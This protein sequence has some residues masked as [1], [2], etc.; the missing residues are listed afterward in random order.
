MISIVICSINT[1]KFVA[2]SESYRQALGDEPHEIIRISNAKSLAE[3]YN[4]GLGKSTGEIVIFSHDDIEIL[5]ADFRARLRQH[6]HQYDVVG[7]AGTNRLMAGGWAAAGPPYVFGQ[8][9]YPQP[10][11]KTVRVHIFGAP[12]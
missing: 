11:S 12:K 2:V 8:I 10:K 6:L 9:A 1:M 4:R 5:T 7:V 3:G